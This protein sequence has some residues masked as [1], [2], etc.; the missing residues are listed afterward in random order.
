MN[1]ETIQRQRTLAFYNTVNGPAYPCEVTLKNDTSYPA[2]LVAVDAAE[3]K[4]VFQGLTTDWGE[5]KKPVT[6]RSCDLAVLT[7]AQNRC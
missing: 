7:F 6:V 2:S 1:A 5:F 3:T 4:F